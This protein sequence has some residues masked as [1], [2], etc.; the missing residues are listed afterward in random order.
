LPAT[1]K[2]RHLEDNMAALRG[3]LPDAA[4]RERIAAAL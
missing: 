3:R 4:M 2:V 1:S